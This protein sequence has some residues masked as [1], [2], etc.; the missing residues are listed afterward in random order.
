MTI[1]LYNKEKKLLT[2][3]PINVIGFGYQEVFQELVSSLD[4]LIND[5]YYILDNLQE[6]MPLLIG[7]LSKTSMGEINHYFHKND[8]LYCRIW[9]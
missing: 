8:K 1:V 3:L 7:K 6:I 5:D 4:K 2:R 9:R